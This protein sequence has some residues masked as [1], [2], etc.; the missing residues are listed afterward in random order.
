MLLDEQGAQ[1]SLLRVLGVF[2]SHKDLCPWSFSQVRFSSLSQHMSCVLSKF[3][4]ASIYLTES[5]LMGLG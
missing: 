1:D 4:V 3:K 2:S 5:T